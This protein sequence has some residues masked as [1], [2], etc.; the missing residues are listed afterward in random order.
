MIDLLK[1]RRYEDEFI[2]HVT[3]IHLQKLQSRRILSLGYFE[4]TQSSCDLLFIPHE[5]NIHFFVGNFLEDDERVFYHFSAKFSNG[6]IVD[7]CFWNYA[8][9]PAMPLKDFQAIDGTIDISVKL[10]VGVYEGEG[11]VWDWQSIFTTIDDFSTMSS[12]TTLHSLKMNELIETGDFSD[13]TLICSDAKE[14]KAHKCLLQAS[15]YFRAILSDSFKDSKKSSINVDYEYTMV[16]AFLS[17]LY[18]GNIS[19]E[20][21]ENWT[22]LF[23]MASFYGVFELARHCELQMMIRTRKNLEMIKEILHFAIRYN[24]N[25]LRRYV[26]RLVRRIQ[27]TA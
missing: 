6:I 9:I 13:V 26:V 23:I 20:K 27:K 14:I 19:E 15:P 2:T 7:Q 12:K 16:K 3:G 4:E 18:S 22:D 10:R 11:S 5:D 21:V 24:A 1:V 8:Q 25:K 17:Y